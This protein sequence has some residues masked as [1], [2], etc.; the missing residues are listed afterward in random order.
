MESYMD[1]DNLSTIA[2]M[3]KE[4]PKFQGLQQAIHVEWSGPPS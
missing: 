2:H 4:I 3:I 1:L